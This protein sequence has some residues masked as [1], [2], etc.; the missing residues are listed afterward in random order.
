MAGVPF[1]YFVAQEGGRRLNSGVVIAFWQIIKQRR[2]LL[3]VDKGSR[4]EKAGNDKK[5]AIN[6]AAIIR[7]FT[8]SAMQSMLIP[9]LLVNYRRVYRRVPIL[10]E[11]INALF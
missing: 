9:L 2:L 1:P 7:R 8:F 3:S 4:R 6:H 11:G 5:E 10:F